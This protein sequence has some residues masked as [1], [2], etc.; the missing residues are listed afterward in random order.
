MG[1]AER[2]DIEFVPLST[3]EG[4]IR[5]FGTLMPALL[6]LKASPG[7]FVQF[8][9]ARRFTPRAEVES[10]VA[11]ATDD[12]AQVDGTMIFAHRWASDG[13]D[14]LAFR[15]LHQRACSIHIDYRAR[16]YASI[17]ERA[18]TAASK[19]THWTSE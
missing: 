11:S 8:Q 12:A 19:P 2:P 9:V 5:F 3:D 18:A 6:L 16:A 14:A 15:R 17:R 7:R 13:V 1:E 10:F 4:K